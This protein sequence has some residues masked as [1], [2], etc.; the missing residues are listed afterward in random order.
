DFEEDG[1]DDEYR[2]LEEADEEVAASVDST[3]DPVRM[4]LMQLGQIP[5][6]TR[7]QEVTAA[8]EIERTRTHYRH[9]ILATDYVLQ[10]AVTL[11]EQVRDGKLRLDRTI[12]VSVTNTSEKK[13][14]MQR[15]GPNVAT[16]RRML[17]ENHADYRAAVNRRLPM[18][19]RRAA[20]RRLIV[21]RNK[22]VR[23]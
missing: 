23:L 9:R 6:L 2:A 20:W 22:A 21:R 12:E 8:I 7:A 16:L 13:K 14:I 17:I 1:I 15:I 3:D 5:L 10:G 4:Y 11:L 19:E 18:D